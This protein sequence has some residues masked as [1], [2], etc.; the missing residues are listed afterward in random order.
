MQTNS[1]AMI[2][3]IHSTESLI[4][5]SVFQLYTTEKLNQLIKIRFWSLPSKEGLS[6]F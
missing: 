2:E 5:I 4:S 3:T 6:T 1:F